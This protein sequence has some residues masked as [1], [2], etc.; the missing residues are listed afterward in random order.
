MKMVHSKEAVR[1]VTR[2]VPGGLSSR[3]PQGAVPG[4]AEGRRGVRKRQGRGTHSCCVSCESW[5]QPRLRL[6][7]RQGLPIWRWDLDFILKVIK[8]AVGFKWRRGRTRALLWKH[9]Q[10]QSG[11]GLEPETRQ[12]LCSQSLG[13]E[14]QGPCGKLAM[15]TEAE[16]ATLVRGGGVGCRL[17]SWYPECRRGI[18]LG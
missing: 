12:G 13:D 9:F 18:I 3:T 8:E 4:M 14:S 6:R 1:K 10:A 5:A 11:D 2:S 16:L 15:R 7:G 17:E